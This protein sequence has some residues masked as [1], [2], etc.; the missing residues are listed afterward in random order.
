MS[1]FRVDIKV[2]N[3]RLITLIEEQYGTVAQF[4]KACKLGQGQVGD[5]CNLK[6]SPIT[7]K[8][9]NDGCY[10]WKLTASNIAE[11]LGVLP[12]EIWP[13][14]LQQIQLNTNK[15]HV[16][17]T[18]EQVGHL[19]GSDRHENPLLGTLKGEKEEIL[20]GLLGTLKD[21][22]LFV[23][24]ERFG[25]V[26][27]QSKTLDEVKGLLGLSRERV[28]QIEAKAMRKIRRATSKRGLDA[29]LMEADYV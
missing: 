26:D 24:S 11:A 25:L 1:D 10:D 22:E 7:K 12:E 6:D 28:R 19:I 15:S 17:V 5:Y 21:Q 8:K 16:V 13:E 14:H 18:A 2:R 9:V 27:G 29:D 23:I 20:Y 3:N 4:A